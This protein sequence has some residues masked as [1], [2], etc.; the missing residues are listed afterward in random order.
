[1]TRERSGPA[2]GVCYYPEQWDPSE[3][4]RDARGMAAIGLDWVRIGEF[5][6]ALVETRRDRFEWEW[7]DE[8]VR[9]LGDAGLKVMLCT[10]TA[11]PPRWLVDERPEILPVGADGRVRGFG[12]RRHYCFS[13]EPYLE[14]AV[15]I[16]SRFAER[17]GGNPHVR[18]WQIDNEFDD[19][20][21]ALSWSP[22]ALAGFRR[23][24]SSRYGTIDALNRA[25]G[26]VHWG[27]VYRAFE[28][29]ELPIWTVDEPNPAHALDFA[30]YSS[31]RVAV[32]CRA[33]AR[34]IRRFAP[35][36]PVSH[37]FMAGSE[38]FDHH[39]VAK[40]LDFA[41][42]D[43]YPLGNLAHGTLPEEE[44][45]RWLRTGAPDYQGFHCDHYRHVGRGRLWIAEQQPG[46][47]NWARYNPSPAEGALRLWT[48]AAYAHGADAVL[49]FRWRQAPFGH[50]Q[51]HSALHLP[52]GTPDPSL[53]EVVRV[54]GERTRL[55]A[56]VRA[57]ASVALIVDYPSRWANR[58]LPQ[59]LDAA[60]FGI[61]LAWY[62]AVREQGVDVDV[63][64]PGADF[65]AYRLV[66]VPDMTIG[67][68][69]CAE[70]LAAGDAVVLLGPRSG[71][72]T[73]EFRTPDDLAPGPFRRLIDLRV[74][75][76]ESFPPWHREPVEYRG[77]VHTVPGWREWVES[78][79]SA[80][81]RF[82]APPRAGSAA[83]LR[84]ERAFYLAMLPEGELLQGI[85]EEVLDAAGIVR[86]PTGADLR[87]TRRG[88]VGFA[89][90]FG[91]E[92]AELPHDARRKFL[93]G[94]DPVAPLDLAIWQ[95]T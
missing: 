56:S 59:G 90:N 73:E 30:R 79:A 27:T 85:V 67:G 75:R 25:W 84:S 43:S 94:S 53:P 36:V 15:R 39:V 24:L 51:F 16:A 69:A 35:Q 77:R 9:I 88:D 28:Q 6:W 33:Q 83:M 49:Y 58:I 10:P 76:V 2:L 63:V 38:A 19:H 72:K 4:K 54:A 13:S 92:P 50:E 44:K 40:D 62:R 65:F 87:I 78:D 32:F 74:V 7:L 18:A 55:P 71:S 21:T 8:A 60:G 93:V 68:E 1:M 66:L 5:S 47:V 41:G 12:A 37:N 82:V 48:W 31:D 80:P 70:S 89:F 81:A 14:E 42:F 11:S 64:G 45:R 23:W 3:W 86:T 26:T 91:G 17:Y 29:V 52:D 95:E 22:A 61:A 34:A 57:P 20:D 46:P